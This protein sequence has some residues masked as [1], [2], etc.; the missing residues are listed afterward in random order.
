MRHA[1]I[2]A[3][4]VPILFGPLMSTKSSKKIVIRQEKTPFNQKSKGVKAYR[5]AE[6]LAVSGGVAST[7]RFAGQGGGRPLPIVA[8][9]SAR[10]TTL[11]LTWLSCFCRPI[12]LRVLSM[13][14]PMKLA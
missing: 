3:N 11:P 6:E 4:M 1:S 2:N 9:Y 12:R 7:C 13:I 14:G 5:F 8:I 10:I